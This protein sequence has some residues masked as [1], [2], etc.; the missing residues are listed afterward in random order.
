MENRQL[1]I[2]IYLNQKIVFDLLTI[3]EQGFSNV[4]KIDINDT[5]NQSN[6]NKDLLFLSIHKDP[7]ERKIFT[8]SA[9][10]SK[11][12]DELKNRK[13]LKTLNNSFEV[14]ELETGDFVEFTALLTKNPLIATIEG[15]IEFM[16]VASLFEQASNQKT[17]NKPQN[18]I[19]EMKKFITKI[20][21]GNTL[22]LVGTINHEIKN[23]KA[24]VPVEYEYLTNKTPA[25]L[26]D[27]HFTVLGKVIKSLDESSKES[28]NLLRGTSLGLLPNQI[29]QE[30]I[31][32]FNPI[33]TMNL[34][35]PKLTF[36]V[37]GP[38]LQIVPI[39]I[40]I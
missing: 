15:F 40:Y 34:Q 11:L 3:I 9:L 7:N 27:G 30:L 39:A 14:N 36:E 37:K 22:D 1:S 4:E 35:L 21:N 2:P 32:Q 5:S 6:E 19:N 29:K 16:E 13:F 25:D 18:V 17:K 23:I 31:Q 28:I 24:V 38:A 8:P 12:R 26:I 20:S 10:F 33:Q